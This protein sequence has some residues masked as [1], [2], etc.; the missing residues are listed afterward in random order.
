MNPPENSITTTPG[1]PVADV[2]DWIIDALAKDLKIP[3]E[4]ISSDQAILSMGVDS[5]QIIS[6]TSNLE[7]WGGFRFPE[8]P[9]EEHPTIDMLSSYVASLTERPIDSPSK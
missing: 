4:S 8:N 6:L 1:R 7:D 5:V 2:R 9:L 3:R